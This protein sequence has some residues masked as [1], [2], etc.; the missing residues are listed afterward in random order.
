MRMHGGKCFWKQHS[1]AVSLLHWK[2]GVCRISINSLTVS[3]RRVVCQGQTYNKHVWFLYLQNVR[4][5]WFIKAWRKTRYSIC[6]PNHWAFFWSS[7]PFSEHLWHHPK[8]VQPKDG[9][10]ISWPVELHLRRK[11]WKEEGL[12]GHEATQERCQKWAS[13]W[14]ARMNIT[15]W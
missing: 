5:C 10:G 6:N 13:L 11:W 15:Q 14:Y 2:I 3:E 1:R 4:I 12:R 7:G 8:L 9:R